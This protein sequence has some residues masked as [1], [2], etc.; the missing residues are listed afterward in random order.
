MSVLL[1]IFAADTSDLQSPSAWLRNALVGRKSSAGV[2]VNESNS[3]SLSAYYACI[4]NISEDIAK[5]P[6]RVYQ[7][8]GEKD[9]VRATN[10]PVYRLLMV[11]PNRQMTPIV[12]KQTMSAHACGWGNGYAEIQRDG[13]NM[14]IALW[15]IHPSRVT[16]RL[17]GDEIVYDVAV[18][19]ERLKMW[20]AR[21]AGFK[22]VTLMQDEMF[23]IQGLGSNGICG[24]SPAALGKESIG[25]ALAAQD[26][27]GGFF[28]NGTTI[29]GILSHPGQLSKPAQERLIESVE[30]RHKGSDKAFRPM[31]LEEGMKWDSTAIPPKD[32]Q[33]LELRQFQVLDI[34]RWF[35]M[36]PH[37]IQ[38]MEAATFSN[39]EHQSIEYVIDC[40]QPWITRWEEEAN[41]KLLGDSQS[42]QSKFSVQALMR[43]DAKSRAE[44]YRVMMNIGAMSINEVRTLEDMNGIGDDGDKYFMQLNMTT[45]DRIG[46]AQPQTTA[47]ASG[48]TS[49]ESQD[50]TSASVADLIEPI[51]LAAV[52]RVNRKEAKALG[53]VHNKEQSEDEFESW[54]AQFK[55]SQVDYM[56]EGIGPALSML[57]EKDEVAGRIRESLANY[58]SLRDYSV[59]NTEICDSIMAAKIMAEIRRE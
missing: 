16:P 38:S 27:T 36:P 51:I 56:M 34:A 57:P 5:L 55:S 39:I 7:W 22:P 28:G 1:K 11:A 35:R 32:A 40:L 10:H 54:S 24:F 44:F 3:M 15:P 23:H 2:N 19:P 30:Q 42:Y 46:E 58:Y 41:R 18:G 4:R 25:A 59:P 14:P 13:A 49:T 43:G 31:V 20:P 45:V 52:Q 47:P 12:F 21:S 50:D 33:F 48:S 26:F 6:F 17:D 53:R 9:K 37:K 29:G 8:L